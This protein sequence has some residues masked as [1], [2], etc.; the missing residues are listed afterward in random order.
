ML[1]KLQHV[2]QQRITLAG[3]CQVVERAQAC[4]H[5][6]GRR[7]VAVGDQQES[8]EPLRLGAHLRC[9]EIVQALRDDLR[10][11]ADRRRSSCRRQRVGN[12]ITTIN[13]QMHMLRHIKDAQVKRIS[14]GRNQLHIRRAHVSL[15]ILTVADDHLRNLEGLRHDRG[16]G[17]VRVDDRG[18][19]ARARLKQLGLRRDQRLHVLEVPDVRVA[20]VCNHCNV[21][22]ADVRQL[23]QFPRLAHS[24]FHDRNFVL[25]AQPV[26][27]VGKPHE[28]VQV[29]LRRQQRERT[30]AD[31]TEHLLRRRL[32]RRAR[33]RD[34]RGIDDLA[35]LA[36]DRTQSIR[37]VHNLQ[38]ERALG[39]IVTM[40][41]HR[42]DDAGGA[43]LQRLRDEAVARK[44]PPVEREE[45][46]PR[47]QRPRVGADSSHPHF[48]IA[49][50]QGS[51][52]CLH[53]FAQHEVHAIGS[54]KVCS[55]STCAKFPRSSLNTERATSRSS[56]GMRFVPMS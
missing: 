39:K 56:K 30:A 13:L 43:L 17:T 25:L 21:G 20:D 19:R 49:L 27:R 23:R 28:V 48:R 15:W 34:H 7:V 47:A 51:A 36:R 41:L 2:R 11:H 32:P 44:I 29:P 52:G 38:Q 8:V 1:A 18:R 45:S 24:R 46:L 4:H 37:C 55:G 9:V 3:K 40:I 12:L 26:E 42:R 16:M 31:E 10:R 6:I 14:V 22:D 33:D 53:N 35:P 50:H 5:R 54:L